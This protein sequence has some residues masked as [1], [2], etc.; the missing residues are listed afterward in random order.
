MR[1]YGEGAVVD[2]IAERNREDG[3]GS[4]MISLIRARQPGFDKV[5]P[6]L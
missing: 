5:D 2:D 4:I 6:E 3:F 1:P